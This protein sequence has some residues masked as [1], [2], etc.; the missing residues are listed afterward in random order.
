MK[1]YIKFYLKRN[2][3]YFIVFGLITMIS[4]AIVIFNSSAHYRIFNS[5]AG[6]YTYSLNFRIV[7]IPFVAMMMISPII[8]NRYRFNRQHSDIIN[9]SGMGEKKIRYY[10]NILMLLT[11]I[12]IFTFLFYLSLLII[13]LKQYGELSLTTNTTVYFLYNYGYIILSYLIVLVLGIFNYFVSYYVF[14]RAHNFVNG[15]ILLIMAQLIMVGLF[16][17]P[18]N[19]AKFIANNYRNRISMGTW[20]Y[21][22]CSMSPFSILTVLSYVFIPLIEA[23]P[24]GKGIS[25]P[26][27]IGNVMIILGSSL[28]LLF[29]IYAIY[30]FIKEDELHIEELLTFSFNKTEAIIFHLF[31]VLLAFF[32][33]IS[34]NTNGEMAIS[35]YVVRVILFFLM[36]IVIYYLIYSFYKRSFIIKKKELKILIPVCSVYI[37]SFIIDLVVL[38]TSHTIFH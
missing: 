13:F 23:N 14:T 8:A 4:L 19:E 3:P 33:G 36:F 31:F 32:L 10:N 28:F 2:L 7:F 30:K 24:G 6:G 9:Q 16:Y 37:I 25:F 18:L 34:F 11:T 17:I 20:L 12:A 21:G 27:G 35:Y 29:S 38:I 1:A 5:N 22:S 26:P 15:I